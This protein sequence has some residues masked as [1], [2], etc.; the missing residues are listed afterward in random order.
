M[1]L[2][3]FE[4]WEAQ[5]VAVEVIAHFTAPTAP[6]RLVAK[7]THFA[8][9]TVLARQRTNRESSHILAGRFATALQTKFFLFR[10]IAIAIGTIF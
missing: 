6:V 3:T 1:A 8:K 4:A 5:I 7:Q 10:S 9:T 2:K